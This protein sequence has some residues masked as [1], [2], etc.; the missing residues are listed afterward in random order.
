M[1]KTPVRAHS[2]GAGAMML[3]G[4]WA[5]RVKRLDQIISPVSRF[6]VDVCVK[7]A[8]IGADD[9][10]QAGEERGKRLEHVPRPA[11]RRGLMNKDR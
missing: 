3:V 10:K 9:V 11:R 6:C 2:T 5:Y 7:H 4:L 1:V 8:L